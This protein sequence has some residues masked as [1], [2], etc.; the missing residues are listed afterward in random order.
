MPVCRNVTWGCA[1]RPLT[2][3]Q[4]RSGVLAS[5]SYPVGVP[6]TIRIAGVGGY[7]V[8]VSPPEAT[9]WQSQS[10]MMPREIFDRL[11]HLGCRNADVIAALNAADG[12]WR[13][14]AQTTQQV[15]LLTNRLTSAQSLLYGTLAGCGSL[16]VACTYL[17]YGAVAW[18]VFAIGVPL[19][20]ALLVRYLRI[21]GALRAAG[22]GP[23]FLP[24]GGLKGYSRRRIV[25][26]FAGWIV[27]IL[28][29]LG[30]FYLRLELTVS[31]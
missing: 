3:C 29:G 16:G 8:T 19:T 17:G 1:A 25:I 15:Q 30:Y 24:P 26:F 4:A 5:R 22:G 7:D 10:P 14:H 18:G 27:L 2:V 13:A 11:T 9:W 12:N 21:L 23:R 28:F 31:H 20:V 6:I